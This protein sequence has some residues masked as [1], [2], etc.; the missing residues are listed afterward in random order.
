[1]T[2]LRGVLPIYA[3][4]LLSA[5]LVFVIRLLSAHFRWNLP[6]VRNL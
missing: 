2:A 5:V 4:M 1:M 6:R 3:S